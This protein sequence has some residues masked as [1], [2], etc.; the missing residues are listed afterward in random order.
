MTLVSTFRR[1]FMLSWGVPV[2]IAFLFNAEFPGAKPLPVGHGPMPAQLGGGRLLAEISASNGGANFTFTLDQA[3]AQHPQFH[4]TPQSGWM[5]DPNGMFQ[6][7]ALYHV[8]FQYNSDAA[9]WGPP[10]WGHV[11]S[12]DLAHW[13][14]LPTALEP[15]TPYDNNGVFS[16][17]ATVVNGTPILLYTGVDNFTEYG[18]YYQTQAMAT[19]SP[20]PPSNP[21]PLLTHWTKSAQNPIIS[22]TPLGGSHSQ[23]RDP[24][25]SW[26][27]DGRHYTA[28]GGQL[29][30]SGSAMLYS[31]S[32]YTTWEYVGLL[33]SQ[34]GADPSAECIPADNG[35]SCDQFGTG[36]RS[37]ECPDFFTVPGLNGGYALKWSDQ[38]LGRT[39]YGADWYV[40]GN[41]PGSY[42]VAN[43]SSYA[44]GLFTSTY[45]EA[46]YTPR[47]LDYGSIYASKSFELDDGRRL[48]MNWV[49]ETS[50]GCSGQCSAGTAFTNASG[51]QGVQTIPRVV[52]YDPELNELV[53]YP[54]V[55]V[56]QLRE[57]LLYQGSV[58]LNQ[59]TP[60]VTAP[61]INTSND[62]R[63]LD[64]ILN[65]T[66]TP[67]TNTSGINSTFEAGVMLIHDSITST[68]VLLIGSMT[69]VTST[70]WAVSSLGVYVD[71]TLSGGATNTTYQGGHE[72]GAVSVPSGGLALDDLQL[73]VLVD[74]SLLE[75]FAN[76]GRGRVASRVYPLSNDSWTV[77]MFATMQLAGSGVLSAVIYAMDSCWV[78]S[79]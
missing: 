76:Q 54:T 56:E 15:D 29:D 43:D 66:L 52:T 47:L 4:I 61:F 24:A 57:E 17:S 5:N 78:D 60:M 51:W 34:T 55:E 72:G 77:S 41:T 20:L 46:A 18:Y 38:V 70:T 42:V 6:L 28:I 39:P 50:V 40:L 32:D 8:F 2:T 10:S 1:L 21:D 71:R 7:G 65:I 62:G 79:V 31:S 11:V 26:Q 14:R 53:F 3:T 16:G 69:R 37:W 49:F 27:Q 30:C 67:P 25:T 13:Q 9:I 19:P 59:T 45:M 58:T 73:R 63:Q 74:H 68:R 75:V 33:A 48:M 36:C 12:S 44:D 23:F 22:N 64:I 35:D